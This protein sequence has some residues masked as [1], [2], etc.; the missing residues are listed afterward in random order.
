MARMQELHRFDTN[1]TGQIQTADDQ[2][3]H[4]QVQNSQEHQV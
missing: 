3:Q 1:S 2:M 4:V